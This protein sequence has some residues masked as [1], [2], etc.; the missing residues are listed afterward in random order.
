LD[1]L[2]AAYELKFLKGNEMTIKPIIATRGELSTFIDLG[3]TTIASHIAR[4]VFAPRKDGKFHVQDVV[5]KI[6]KWQSHRLGARGASGSGADDSNKGNLTE[7][8]IAHTVA[9]TESVAL[10]TARARGEVVLLDVIADVIDARDNA[11]RESIFAFHSIAAQLVGLS[12]LEIE[13]KLIQKSTEVLD[14]L[15]DPRSIAW[16]RA[17]EAVEFPAE[18][19]KK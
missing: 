12:A 3:L 17:S 8:R 2:Y 1:R 4:G 7:A 18:A 5:A 13:D 15:S 19:D 10:K 11:I 9:A 14:A 6:I 16:Q